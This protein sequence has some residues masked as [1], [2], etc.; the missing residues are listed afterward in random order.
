MIERL[1]N[2]ELKIMWKEFAVAHLK[3]LFSNSPGGIKQNQEESLGS[4]YS[5]RD[6]N[7]ALSEY[8]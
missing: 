2:D 5:D 4:L 6:W 8:S 7:P 1:I 3:P